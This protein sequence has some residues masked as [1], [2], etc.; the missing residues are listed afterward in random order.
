M[1]AMTSA[2]TGSGSELALAAE[3]RNSLGTLHWPSFFR[4]RVSSSSTTAP[5]V[6][7][8]ATSIANRVSD[9]RARLAGGG[10]LCASPRWMT[11]RYSCHG[12]AGGGG[13]MIG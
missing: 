3:I 4:V 9:S 7:E 8:D 5:L 10:F 2:S 6:L 12:G 11:P 13:A 1:V